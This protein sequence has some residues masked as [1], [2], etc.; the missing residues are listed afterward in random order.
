MLTFRFWKRLAFTSCFSIGLIA[1]STS[2]VLSDMVIDGFSDAH[3]DRFTNSASFVGVNY[4]FSGV[5][6][7]GRWGALIS[8][9]VMLT[10]THYTISGNVNFYPGNDPGQAPIQRTVVGGQQ[11][12]SSDLWAVVL[13]APVPA[14]IQV[15][16]FANQEL[17]YVPAIPP[18]IAI[19]SAGVFQDELAFMMGIS[20][21]AHGSA[22]IDQSVGQNV[23]SGYAEDVPFL[24]FNDNDSIILEYD[25]PGISFESYVQSG[26]SGAPLFVVRNGQLLLLGVNS[27]QL[28]GD[29]GYRASGITYTGNLAAELN[30]IIAANANP[31]PGT[32]VLFGIGCAMLIRP[33]RRI[34]LVHSR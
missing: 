31:E 24:G 2:V 26:D 20:Q 4:D 5:A 15:Y 11:V 33:R 17:S 25:N 6:R 27:F 1:F 34:R 22:A 19:E 14:S 32:L 21:T 30:G 13:D 10:A 23:I 12:G 3:N 7:N 16:Q 8:P 9:N 18:G 28:T 29:N